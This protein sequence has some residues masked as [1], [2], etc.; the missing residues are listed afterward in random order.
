MAAPLTKCLVSCFNVSKFSLERSVIPCLCQ[1]YRGKKTKSGGSV[2]NQNTGTRG[3]DRGPK[4]YD[5]MFVYKGDVLHTQYGLTM[6]PGENV[7]ILRNNS[8]FAL[9]DGIVKISCEKLQPFPNSPLYQRVQN[10]MTIYKKF[11]N[12]YPTPLHAKFKLV[13][14]S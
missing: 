7:G 14:E 5:G 9:T 2:R 3:K 8:L 12:I 10:G 11:Y 13:S 1:P 4:K 6:Y